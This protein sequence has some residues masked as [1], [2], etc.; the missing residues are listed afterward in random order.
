MERGAPTSPTEVKIY[1]RFTIAVFFSHFDRTKP[2]RQTA[3]GF[4][5]I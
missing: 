3:G 5:V 4:V 2:P 1:H